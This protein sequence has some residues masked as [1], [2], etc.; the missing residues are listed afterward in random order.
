MK[1][2]KIIIVLLLPLFALQSRAQ[3]VFENQIHNVK[4]TIENT[5]KGTLDG[6]V[7]IPQNMGNHAARLVFPRNLD[8]GYST[9]PWSKMPLKQRNSRQNNYRGLPKGNPWAPIGDIQNIPFNPSA[10]TEKNPY[11]DAPRYS[12]RMPAKAYN[13]NSYGSFQNNNSAF[14]SG[15]N[16]QYNNMNGGLFSPL[17]NNFWPGANN[18]NS[19]MPFMPW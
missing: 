2:I 7:N 19:S 15:F 4:Q 17:S 1:I 14:D 9:N 16:Q 8:Q 5:I 11:T 3:D 18:V 6:V 10:M 13:G 12:Q